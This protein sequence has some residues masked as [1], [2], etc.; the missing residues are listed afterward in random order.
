MAIIVS[1]PSFG[2]QTSSNDM[3]EKD[4]NEYNYAYSIG[5]Q[6]MVYGWAPVMMDVAREL[7]TSVDHP[8]SNGQA[9]INELGPITRLW[10]YRD[11]SYTTPNNDTYYIQG[12]ADLDDQPMVLFV[13]KI[14]NRYWIE[15]IL[16][17]YTESVVDLCNATVG[18]EGGYFILAKEGYDGPL[19]E[20]LPVYYSRTKYIWL[21]GRIGVKNNKDQKIARQ[22]QKE[23]RL[24]PLDQY[25]NG[26]SQPTPQN[27][28]EA[29]KVNFPQGLEWFKRLEV[30]I[31]ENPLAED[32]A[33][34]DTFKEIGIG[35]N[36]IDSISEIKALALQQAYID[37]FNIILDAARNS[38]QPVNGWNWEYNAG[39]YGTDYL[40]RS[41]I[42][43]NSIGLNSP[44]RAM[45]PKRYVDN[46]GVQ[47]NGNNSYQITLPADIP[48]REQDGGFWSITMYDAKDRFMVENKIDRYKIGSTT[49]K[50]IKNDDGSLTIYISHKQP[51]DKKMKAN[52]LPAPNEDFMLQFRLYEPEKE[53][54]EGSYKLPQ[55]YKID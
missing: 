41:S 2:M 36:S 45:Y 17:M 50:L 13:P 4:K 16:D 52:W 21:A 10:D 24:M 35:A 44:E 42:N 55:L 8:M 7:Q 31:A 32:Q 26:P 48:V 15:Q 20:N 34:V 6:A 1:M 40:A 43:M 9:P 25:P 18:E 30:V 54:Y 5:V 29:P 11:R 12:W 39:V 53:V 51:K 23:F 19:P 46:K 22:I 47:L 27:S 14:E 38:S 28:S 49:E 37:G 3:N 33:I